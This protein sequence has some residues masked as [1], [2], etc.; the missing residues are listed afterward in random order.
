ML[1]SNS[2][3]INHNEKHKLAGKHINIDQGLDAYI[4]MRSSDAPVV[5]VLLHKIIDTLLENISLGN[6]YKSFSGALD[7]VNSFIKLWRED[8]DIKHRLDIAIIIA[9]NNALYFSTV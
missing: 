5:E 9:D 7:K 1:H 6:T 4:I 8:S 2:T 3:Q